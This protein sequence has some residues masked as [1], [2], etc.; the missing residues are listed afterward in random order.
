MEFQ[1]IFF[2]IFSAGIPIVIFF[3]RDFISKNS[4][5]IYGQKLS[6][7]L[8]KFVRLAGRA[9]RRP[10]GFGT[11]VKER[12]QHVRIYTGYVLHVNERAAGA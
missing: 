7:Y 5:R 1:Y 6:T 4:F 9:Q 11:L 2:E 8:A 10:I 12:Y 3:N